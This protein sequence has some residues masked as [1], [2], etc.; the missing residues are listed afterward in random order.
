[1]EDTIPSEILSLVALVIAFTSTIINY[2]LLRL[3]RDPE[4]IVYAASDH[5]R[6]SIINLVIENIGKGLAFDVKFETNRSIPQRAFGFENAPNPKPMD[7]GPLIIGIPSLGVGEKRIITWGQFGGLNKGL[8]DDVLDIT[9]TYRSC[10]MLRFTKQKH[11]TK[12]RIDIK[13]FKGTDASDHNCDKKAAEQLGNIAKSLINLTD[14]IQKTLGVALKQE[15]TAKE[16]FKK[17]YG[18][19]DGKIYFK[20]EDHKKE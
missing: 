5:R 7:N 1:M 15:E 16:E 2:L 12:S 4:V 17:L 13:S 14:I 10:P 18:W 19:N 6:P 11:K 3:H 20:N 9:A 8:G